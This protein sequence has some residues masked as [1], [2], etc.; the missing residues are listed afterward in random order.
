MSS[1][2]SPADAAAARR[3]KILAKSAERMSLVKGELTQSSDTM[4]SPTLTLTKKSETVTNEVHQPL[5]DKIP[6]PSLIEGQGANPEFV[7]NE[8][9]HT[10]SVAEKKKTEK[11]EARDEVSNDGLR[12]RG[13]AVAEVVRSDE[14][15]SAVAPVVTKSA[16][17]SIKTNTKTSTS[18]SSNGGVGVLSEAA[19]VLRRHQQIDSVEAVLLAGFPVVLGFACAAAWNSCGLLSQ[20]SYFLQ[21]SDDIAREDDTRLVASRKLFGAESMLMTPLDEGRF[22]DDEEGGTEDY[23]KIMAPLSSPS[24]TTDSILLLVCSHISKRAPL[25]AP[26]A[27]IAVCIG[28]A[29][30]SSFF[31][32][33][34]RC[35][36]TATNSI[37]KDVLSKVQAEQNGASQAGMLG[38]LA[39]AL[40]YGNVAMK[41]Y[42]FGKSVFVD[43]SV[44]VVSWII[45]ASILSLFSL[46]QQ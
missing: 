9:N 28:R 45:L 42:R 6:V 31:S 19:R 3:A 15:A 21:S 10:S 46:T 8:A 36:A 39:G 38:M 33:V 20:H 25:N 23:E 34:K 17:T 29:I 35:F 32:L 18:I 41:W 13:H 43:V 12:R 22:L 16:E 2:S 11:P 7:E 5:D 37:T 26:V 44:L 24:L 4:P 1:S 27:L 30:I 14:R 40:K